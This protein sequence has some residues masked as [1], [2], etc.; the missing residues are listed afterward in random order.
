VFMSTRPNNFSQL[1][2]K[3]AKKKKWGPDRWDWS[4]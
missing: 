2:K 3:L 1:Y 4:N